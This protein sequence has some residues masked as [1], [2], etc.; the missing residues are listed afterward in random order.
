MQILCGS[1]SVS[2]GSESCQDLCLHLHLP[3]LPSLV[4]PFHCPLPQNFMDLNSLVSDPPAQ[5]FVLS[6]S[7]PDKLFIIQVSAQKPS[8]LKVSSN[9]LPYHFWKSLL[10]SLLCTVFSLHLPPKVVLFID[11][12]TS[13]LIYYVSLTKF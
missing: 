4:S 13:L 10:T 11:L 7:S 1:Y 8:F 6:R 3:T 9:H 12:F 2:Y 5:S